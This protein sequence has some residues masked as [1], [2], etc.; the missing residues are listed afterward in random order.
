MIGIDFL[1]FDFILYIQLSFN[2]FHA[3]QYNLSV[4]RLH[5][6]SPI[7]IGV[8]RPMLIAFIKPNMYHIKFCLV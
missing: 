4:L 5:K 1:P 6:Y 8:I 2:S 3:F 7:K